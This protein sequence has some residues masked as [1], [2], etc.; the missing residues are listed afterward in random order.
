MRLLLAT[1]KL[2]LTTIFTL[3]VFS[4]YMVAYF[5]IWITR[6]PYEYIRN[7]FMT[8]W[9]KGMQLLLGVRL[10]IKGQPPVRPFLLFS[11]HLTYL[12]PILFFSHLDCTFVAKKEV[13]SWP[14]IGFMVY[15][16]GVIFINR[17]QKKDLLRVTDLVDQ[18]INDKQGIV[19]FPEG[20]TSDG[21]QIL[22]IRAPLLQLA[23]EDGNPLAYCVVTYQTGKGDPDASTHVCWS[24]H[25]SFGKHVWKFASVKRT[26]ATIH[27]GEKKLIASNRKELAEQLRK[28]MTL[29]L[30]SEPNQTPQNH[31]LDKK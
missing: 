30:H 16:M 19:I 8:F 12:D 29:L 31:R 9:G 18:N 10:T 14:I 6:I 15:M 24:N 28:E 13:R 3:T 26:Y 21:K 22:P 4:V 11:N 7:P 20:T 1:L 23:F 5:F 25:E 2:G 27:Y 17:E